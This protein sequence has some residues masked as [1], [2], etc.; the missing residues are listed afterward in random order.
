M[1]WVFP[2]NF[3]LVRKITEPSVMFLQNGVLILNWKEN[4]KA[5]TICFKIM[6]PSKKNKEILR[7][8]QSKIYGSYFI[9]EINK[10]IFWFVNYFEYHHQEMGLM[11]EWWKKLHKCST[12]LKTFTVQTCCLYTFNKSTASTQQTKY[13]FRLID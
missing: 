6:I 3:I 13:G 4:M 9:M 2:L 12:F 11:A 10:N 5:G 8:V 1:I 7:K